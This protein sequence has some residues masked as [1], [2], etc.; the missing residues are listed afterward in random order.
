MDRVR[1]ELTRV[2]LCFGALLFI[3]GCTA[4]AVVLSDGGTAPQGQVSFLST[5]SNVTYVVESTD[6]GTFSF[7][8]SVAQSSTN[9]PRIP[10]GQ[11]DIQFRPPDSF[12][13]GSASPVTV[14]YSD[15]CNDSYTGKSVPCSLF[16]L[17]LCDTAAPWGSNGGACSNG[18]PTDGGFG[19]TQIALFNLAR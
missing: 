4:G 18:S 17:V 10:A 14:K 13:F 19:I 11:Y 7:D 1:T 9:G 16:G 15:S 3:G 6:A 8:P 5:T 2:S 12:G